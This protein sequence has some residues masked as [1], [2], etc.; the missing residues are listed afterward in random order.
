MKL[1][2][3]LGYVLDTLYAGLTGGSAELPLPQNT[4]LN[5]VQPG[6]PFDES[7]FDFAI[8]GPFAG[9]SALTLDYFKKLVETLMGD[10][11]GDGGLSRADAINQAKVMYQQ[12]LLGSWEQWSR[13]VDFIPI[14]N[15]T[16][17]QTQWQLKPGEGKQ[18]HVGIVYAQAGQTVSNVYDDTLQRCWVANE[19]LTDQQKKI[20]ERAKALLQEEVEVEDLLTGD[21]KTEIRESRVMTAYKQKKIDY[22]NAVIDYATRLARANNGTAADLVEWS[23]SGGIYKRRAAQALSDWV[24]NGYKDD[25]EKAQATIDHITG[26]S[27]VAWMSRLTQDIEMVRDNVQGAFGYSFFPAALLPGG[28]ARS[29]GWARLSEHELHKKHRSSSSSRDWGASGGLNL[30]FLRIGGS[31]GGHKSDHQVSFGQESFG[32]DFEYTQVEIVRP[33]FN[34]N[35]FL[36][37]GWK[38][39]DEFIRDHNGQALHSDG[40]EKPQGVMIGYPTKALFIRNLTITSQSLATFMKMH[41]D[42]VHAGGSVGWGP[43]CLGGHY[44]QSNAQSQYNLD[45]QGAT[46]TV[47]G[48]QLVGFLSALFPYSANPDP[49]VKKWI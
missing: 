7:A 25:V 20:I 31:G 17:S 14:V 23:Q 10:Q 47:R 44:A 8:A 1:E 32:I 15:P 35:F 4:I 46:V 28:F 45:V 34:P 24:A 22:E 2:E 12:N 18:Q 39:K 13:L 33:W 21:K 27:M 26:S 11:N 40:K 48:L 5:W 42:D 41:E 9:P 36:S 3:L 6:L 30:G 29:A 43:F 38:P 19:E 37:R 49:N 16:E